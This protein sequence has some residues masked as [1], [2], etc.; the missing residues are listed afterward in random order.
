MFPYFSSHLFHGVL[1][2]ATKQVSTRSPAE[3]HGIRIGD[4]VESINGEQISTTTEA[5][6]L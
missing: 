5:G 3:K 1:I 4:I 2:I 6:V